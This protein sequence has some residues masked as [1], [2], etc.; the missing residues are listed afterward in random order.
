MQ[1]TEVNLFV[2]QSLNYET[3][4]LNCSLL[5]TEITGHHR[6]SLQRT[7]AEE[8]TN[9]VDSGE[10]SDYLLQH[11]FNVLSSNTVGLSQSGGSYILHSEV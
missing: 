5:S 8:E 10:N 4:T 6:R 11:R 1:R 2:F 9:D 7:H 3:P